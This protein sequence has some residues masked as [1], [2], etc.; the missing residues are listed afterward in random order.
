MNLGL[1]FFAIF[2]KVGESAYF[3]DLEQEKAVLQNKDF[4]AYAGLH[5]M[6]LSIHDVVTPDG[7][8]LE[9]WRVRNMEIFDAEVSSP[10]ILGHGFVGTAFDFIWNLRNESAAFILADSGY[11]VWLPNWRGNHFSDRILDEGRR[12]K[13]TAEE[14]YRSGWQYMAEFDF[15]SVIEEVLSTTE[16]SKIYVAGHSM[17]GTLMSAFLSTNHTFDGQISHFAALTPVLRFG[18]DT[19]KTFLAAVLIGPTVVHYLPTFLFRAIFGR[20]LLA[21]PDED[22]IAYIRSLVCNA[23]PLV[24]H[25]IVAAAVG[26]DMQTLRFTDSHINKT[27]VEVYETEQVGGTGPMA[28]LNF[29]DQRLAIIWSALDFSSSYPQ[30]G[31]T[32]TGQYGSE[33]PTQYD[34]AAIEVPISIFYVYNDPFNGPESAQG[35]IDTLQPTFSKFIEGDSL[36]HNDVVLATDSRCYIYNDVVATFDNLEN[37]RDEAHRTYRS[38]VEAH[39]RELPYEDGCVGKSS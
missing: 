4:V 18:L 5:G 30:T 9:V 10:V 36:S 24:C 22:T 37:E 8:I 29:A 19:P 28:A 39:L 13:P 33:T 20:Q 38:R 7:W 21:Y 12:R 26:R 16:Q 23:V 27:R 6:N 35:V 17:G 11:D 32:N 14:Y 15:P 1:L 3:P 25:L 2:A 31:F 34:F